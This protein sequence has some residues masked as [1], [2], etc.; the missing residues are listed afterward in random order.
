MWNNQTHVFKLTIFEY[1][2]MFETDNNF[3]IEIDMIPLH[4]A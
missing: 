1:K 4:V 2:Q 3:D